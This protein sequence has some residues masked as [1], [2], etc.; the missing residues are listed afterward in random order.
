[1]NGT[2]GQLR[3]TN[4]H[5]YG[6]LT[7]EDGSKDIFF[8]SHELWG[9]TFDELRTGDSVGWIVV[10]GPKGPA[11]SRVVRDGYLPGE[12]EELE[13][14]EKNDRQ[15]AVEPSVHAAVANYARTLVSLVAANPR[16]LDA[17][18]WRD[19]ERLVAEA[20]SG[21][22]FNVTLMSGSKDGGKDI[23]IRY[24]LNGTT[25]VYLVQIKHWVGKRVGRKSAMEFVH[26]IASEA[27]DGGVFLA[28]S[29]YARTALEYL[30]EIDRTKVILG[31]RE[32]IVSVCRRYQKLS[33]LLWA[34]SQD[35]ADVIAED[36]VRNGSV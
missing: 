19:V 17:I 20:F 34:P 4:G 27:A 1:M 23:I 35:L 13:K 28:T 8:H 12:L 32:K 15:E 3:E 16:I 26:V 31:A 10:E 25:K 30:Y 7:P 9:I 5:C 33:P 14:N 11:A 36:D 2:V 24:T 21:I 22:G 18:E 29:G 6:F